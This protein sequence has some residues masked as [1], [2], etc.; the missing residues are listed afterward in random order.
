MQTISF[1][2]IMILNVFL[3][4]DKRTDWGCDILF[5]YFLKL[6]TLRCDL[7]QILINFHFTPICVNRHFSFFFFYWRQGTKRKVKIF[8][9]IM[10]NAWD[11][12]CT[13]YILLEDNCSTS[14]WND[15]QVTKST[16]PFFC[17]ILQHILI[18]GAKQSLVTSYFRN[19]CM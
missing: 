10:Q 3:L 14:T 5:E 19:V 8:I 16:F 18:T 1:W 7:Q 2:D 13:H 17:K 15:K 6:F 12:I 4:K 11:M 9:R